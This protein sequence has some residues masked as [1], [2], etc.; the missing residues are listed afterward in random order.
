MN[1]RFFIWA[2]IVGLFLDQATKIAVYGMFCGGAPDY[3]RV[4]PLLGD[5]LKLTYAQN[6]QGV[7]GLRYGPQFLYF[8]L[9]LSAAGLVI[10]YGLRSKDGWSSTAFGMILAGA[11]GNVID[12]AR[13]GYVIDFI[14]CEWRRV[15]FQWFTFNVADALVVVGA[16]M[17]LGK[18]FLGR[19]PAEKDRA[20]MSNPQGMTK[21]ENTQA[22]TG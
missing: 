15:G 11:L 19:R 17:L 22:G 6:R 13:L 18:E 16:I 5:V 2:A 12:R 3:L 9:P 1:R 14:V 7:F 8:L 21:E 10:W 20:P 4:A